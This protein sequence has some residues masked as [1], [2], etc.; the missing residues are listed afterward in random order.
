MDLS[1]AHGIEIDNNTISNA[2]NGI[3]LTYVR[4]STINGN[5]FKR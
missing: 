4:D 2:N 5:S 1:W 3:H